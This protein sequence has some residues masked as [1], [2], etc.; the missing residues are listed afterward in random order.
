MNI[1]I[2]GKVYLM[3]QRKASD[4]LTLAEVKIEG[5]EGNS[6]IL[7]M[8]VAIYDSLVATYKDISWFNIFKKLKYRRIKSLGHTSI[9]NRIS[10][11]AIIESF[12]GLLELEGIIK[13][14]VLEV[15][16]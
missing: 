14:K 8:V 1:T 3:T 15:K 10:I 4:V 13:K 9:L 12:Q 7:L 6:N 5:E 16:E 11:Q 2:K